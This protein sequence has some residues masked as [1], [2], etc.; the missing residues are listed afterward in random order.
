MD[1]NAIE[2]YKKYKNDRS[3]KKKRQFEMLQK[4]SIGDYIANKKKYD[5]ELLIL[6]VSGYLNNLNIYLENLKGYLD[7]KKERMKLEIENQ[8]ELLTQEKDELLR[9][10][11]EEEKDYKIQKELIEIDIEKLKICL[12]DIKTLIK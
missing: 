2:Q 1:I 3:L 9:R 4:T 6:E 7:T 8:I 5:E 10:E 11:K 12:N